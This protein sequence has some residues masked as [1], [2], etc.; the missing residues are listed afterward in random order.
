[1]MGNLFDGSTGLWVCRGVDLAELVSTVHMLDRVCGAG[2]CPGMTYLGG[3]QSSCSGQGSGGDWLS[4][5][6]HPAF[7]FN[8]EVITTYLNADD[9]EAAYGPYWETLP[10][11]CN[12]S[13]NGS[14]EGSGC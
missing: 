8:T 14:G 2:W 13:G 12:G 11:P 6:P 10:P 4:C 5:T 7:I 9:A 1:F 3:C